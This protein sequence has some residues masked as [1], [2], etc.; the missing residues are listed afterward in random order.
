MRIFRTTRGHTHMME[1]SRVGQSPVAL[2]EDIVRYQLEE[3]P[4]FTDR[5]RNRLL[6]C[7]RRLNSPVQSE[8]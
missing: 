6:K 3:A 7:Q 2:K 1:S 4:V 5:L 8:S